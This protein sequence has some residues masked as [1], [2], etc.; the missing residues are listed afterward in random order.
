MMSI[1]A[2]YKLHYFLDDTAGILLMNYAE[3]NIDVVH[4]WYFLN[5]IFTMCVLCNTES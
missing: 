4:L 2:Y 5:I 3:K 1:F